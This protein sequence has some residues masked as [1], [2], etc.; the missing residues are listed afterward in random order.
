VPD[1][2]PPS[3]YNPLNRQQR[4]FPQCVA[5]SVFQGG[6]IRQNGGRSR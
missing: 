1:H 4:L 2:Q 3:G 6:W 5:C